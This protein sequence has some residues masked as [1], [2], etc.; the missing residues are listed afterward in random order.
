[1]DIDR[2][3]YR[4]NIESMK[5]HEIIENKIIESLKFKDIELF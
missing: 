4:Y 5:E 2:S 3:N 1:M